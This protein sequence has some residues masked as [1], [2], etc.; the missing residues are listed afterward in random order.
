[1]VSFIV[2]WQRKIDCRDNAST[3]IKLEI[4]IRKTSTIKFYCSEKLFP[5]TFSIESVTVVE[6]ADSFANKIGKLEFEMSKFL[7]GKNIAAPIR[8]LYDEFTIP[9]TD[10]SCKKTVVIIVC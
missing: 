9:L 7:F 4:L 8:I 6:I 2:S 10:F 3:R 1:M 5:I